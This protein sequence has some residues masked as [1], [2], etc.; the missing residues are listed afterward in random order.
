MQHFIL[1]NSTVNQ[2]NKLSLQ[3]RT[4]LCWELQQLRFN[5]FGDFTVIK[6]LKGDNL[7]KELSAFIFCK[8]NFKLDEQFPNF[9]N[10]HIIE[11]N[12]NDTKPSSIKE[13]F[14]NLRIYFVVLFRLGQ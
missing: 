1:W 7:S 8:I 11:P 10:D 5:L 12:S 13:Q 2:I 14:E 4:G 9:H 6:C 3:P